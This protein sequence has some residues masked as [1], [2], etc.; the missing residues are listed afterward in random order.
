MRRLWRYAK[1]KPIRT[2]FALL[3]TLSFLSIFSFVG[4][5]YHYVFYDRGNLP[6]IKVIVNFDPP[7]VGTIY[8]ENGKTIINLAKE[9]RWISKPEEI[10]EV[11]RRAMLSA[12][13]KNFYE[14]D[15]VDWTAFFLR[16]GVR[17]LVHVGENIYHQKKPVIQAQQGAS[18]LD[19]Q[20]IRSSFLQEA[21]RH[22]GSNP[23]NKFWRKFEEWRLATWLNEE[24][25]KPEYF[26]S[27][28]NAKEHILACLLSYA[29]FKGVY[30][31]K[32][33][34][35]FYFNKDVGELGYEEAALLAGI[36]KN[37]LLYAPSTRKPLKTIILSYQR[38]LNRRNSVLELMVVN[39]YLT[40]ETAD[41]LK[42][43]ELPLPSS[44]NIN[45]QTDAP[46]V[47][48]DV[49][50]EVKKQNFET[51]KI[52]D[53]EIQVYTTVNLEIQKI[54]NQ[55]MENGLKLYE[56]RYPE[57][58]G[59][60]QGSAVVLRNSDG[61]ILAEVGG[62]QIF[63]S[64]KIT[65]TD[66]NRVRHSLRQPGS[67]FKPFV[68]LTA[69]KDGWTLESEIRDAPFSV[70]M[71][72][73][74]IGNKWVKRPPKW[75]KN[76]DGKF[77]GFIPLRKALAESRNVPTVRLARII[78]IDDVIQ[79]TRLVGIKTKLEPYITTSLGA[80]EVNLLEL[81]NAY[82]AMASGIYAEPYL[83]EKLIDKKGKV[84]FER[85][86]SKKFLNIDPSV[87]EQIQEGLR[88]TVRIP[89]GTAHSLD[90]KD[91]PIPVAGKTGTTNDSKDT[92]FF[93]WTYGLE[94]ITVGVWIGFDEPSVGYDE[95]GI[96]GTGP[97]RGLGSK[98]TGGRTALPVFREIMLNIYKNN[99]AGPVPE[100]PEE[101]ENNID[102]YLGNPQ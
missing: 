84:I 81:A 96:F 50:E 82:R 27:K 47:V 17:N 41:R 7:T 16:A 33:A 28:Q 1:K 66:F 73:V 26:G 75:I 57:A 98:E 25:K 2:M 19:Q 21:V 101:I 97:G 83:M 36:M 62:R 22:E 89:G 11:V 72:Y 99:L 43:T 59:K 55:A 40:K 53:G 61:A 77:R 9:F 35:L 32:A 5:V 34:S 45:I 4:Y 71:G 3:L 6:D 91:F 87:L 68:Y 10:P 92:S 29:Y 65:Y 67:A 69:F 63:N 52:F 48:G 30:G 93:G 15:G 85:N 51:D 42:E 100:F 38:Q 95:N 14:H 80:S 88:G 54:A 18:T 37:P 56:E 79:T 13:D 46:S 90:S 70:P 74:K 94:G 60:I 31:I 12:E 24:L 49:L 44:K 102:A 86:D 58:E 39:K 20:L 78:G 8:D 23:V 76:Y 64:R